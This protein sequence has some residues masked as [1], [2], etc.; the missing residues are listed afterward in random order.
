MATIVA[1]ISLSWTASI[2]GLSLIAATLHIE[3]VSVAFVGIAAIGSTA[4]A[5][6]LVFG[7]VSRRF[8]QQADAFAAQHLSGRSRATESRRDMVIT[9]PAAIAMASALGLVARRNHIPRE[10]FSFRHGSIASRQRNIERLVGTPAH[11]VPV[12]RV[13]GAIKLGSAVG[14]GITIALALMGV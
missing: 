2:W 14:V 3:D 11:R 9:A 5:A 7:W 13:V 10:A 12:D 1:T 8:E 4:V 6:M